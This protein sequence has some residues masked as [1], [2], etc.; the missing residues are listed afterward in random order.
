M[1]G[2][3]K[4]AVLKD[5][6]KKQA[7]K[8]GID[9]HQRECNY[10]G[11]CRGT[12]PKCKAEELQLNAEL[13]KRKALVVGGAL[14]VALSLTACGGPIDKETIVGGM[15]EPPIIENG[16]GDENGGLDKDT[17]V[18]DPKND[19]K[20]DITVNPKDDP[21]NRPGNNLENNLPDDG[22]YEGG[23]EEIYVEPDDIYE[24]EGDVAIE[25]EG[26]LVYDGE[27]DKCEINSEEDVKSIDSALDRM[28]MIE[29][30]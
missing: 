9:L 21:E 30:D 25:V 2:K 20:N 5:I 22:L 14:G 12:C 13:L 10:E 17:S 16:S 19:P 15:D 18:N 24:L 7:E 8:L 23:L 28:F 4:C 11:E 6:R 1:T 27:D 26:E 3:E 29:S